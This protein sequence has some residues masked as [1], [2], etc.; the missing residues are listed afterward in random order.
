[1]I[2]A[3]GRG[4]QNLDNQKWEFIRPF[5]AI[6]QLLMAGKETEGLR[7]GVIETPEKH[8]LRWKEA[9]VHPATGDNPML[10]ELGQAAAAGNHTRLHGLRQGRELS[11]AG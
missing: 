5:F 7:Y 9:D 1:M 6:V 8:W 3:W 2:G 11:N 4:I 10:R